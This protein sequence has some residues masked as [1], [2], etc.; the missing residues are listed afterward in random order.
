MFRMKNIWIWVIAAIVVIAA[1]Y[2]FY[3]SSQGSAAPAVSDDGTSVAADKVDDAGG[4]DAAAQQQGGTG[5]S[6]TVTAGTSAT[7]TYDGKSFS[8][9]T[10]TIKKGGTVTFT[11]TVSSMWVASAPHPAHT[12]YDGTSRQQHCAAGYSGPAPFDQCKSGTSY[13]FTFGKVGTWPYHDHANS[14]A[15]G[16]VVVVE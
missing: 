9:S 15:F 2:W 8:P 7:V 11:S 16:K 1:G 12:G 10:V 4:G 14:S 6:A 3:I 5:V 13:S